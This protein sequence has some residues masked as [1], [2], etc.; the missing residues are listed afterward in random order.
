M[1]EQKYEKKVDYRKEISLD[2][3]IEYS[4]VWDSEVMTIENSPEIPEGELTVIKDILKKNGV[5][6]FKANLQLFNSNNK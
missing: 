4:Y 2:G 6:E 1:N 5:M 3:I